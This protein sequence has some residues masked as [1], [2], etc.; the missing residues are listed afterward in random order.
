M[1]LNKKVIT[2]ITLVV[3]LCIILTCIAVNNHT[4]KQSDATCKAHG[5]IT[6]AG[7]VA[8][9]QQNDDL[10]SAG[11]SSTVMGETVVDIVDMG[12]TTV[13]QPSKEE[14]D[15]EVEEDLSQ[16]DHF[17][18]TNLGLA[19]VDGNL[20][21]RNTPGMDGEIVGKM[22]NYAA[23]EI[24]G[25][26]NGWYKVE[27]ESGRYGYS[28]KSYI[29]P[30]TA[31]EYKTVKT[32]S[33]RLN[34]RKSAGG[35]I[36]NSLASG[37]KVAV[38]STSGGWSK[39]VYNGSSIGFVSSNYLI[40]TDQNSGYKAIK[41]NVPDYK[42]T[43]SRWANHKIGNTN[44]TI[45]LIGCTTTALAMAESYRTGTTIYPNKMEEKLT[46]NSSGALY[47]PTNYAT[48]T[49]FNNYLTRIY[50]LLEQG[51][52]V[53]VGAKKADGGQHWVVVTGIKA[54]NSLKATDFIINDPG[55]STRTNLG[56]FFSTYH[57]LHR[58]AWYK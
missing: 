41:L 49:D 38:L 13:G 5:I 19:V 37:S 33:G 6:S 26:E 21:V 39:V 40:S 31:S 57:Y 42:Q 52:P 20:N 18:Y 15:T 28:S 44:Q 29:T 3:V 47:W 34:V 9:I 54:T 36:I 22:T 11:A 27:Y 14:S 25:E 56:Q 10:I 51:K 45:S 23:C 16:Y 50:S 12:S 53:I 1:T 8:H 32:T 24:L 17:G 2:G 48:T 4:D 35:E 46:Y 58:I 7:A 55:T 30:I 43:D